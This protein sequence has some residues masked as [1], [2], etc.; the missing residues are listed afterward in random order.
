MSLGSTGSD[1]YETGSLG[2]MAT[3]RVLRVSILW[4]NWI[5]WGLA[6]NVTFPTQSAEAYWMAFYFDISS[7][8]LHE[9]NTASL[10]QLV[11]KTALDV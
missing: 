11:P 8:C 7:I 6:N 4:G 5:Y 1:E 10:A 2:T 3:C 9:H